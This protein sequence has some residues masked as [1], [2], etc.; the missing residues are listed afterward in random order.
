M[1][2]VICFNSAINFASSLVF[3]ISAYYAWVYKNSL[4]FTQGCILILLSSI[5]YHG[6]RTLK[7]DTDLIESLKIIDIINVHVCTL[8]FTYLSFGFNIWYGLWWIC[9]LYM[10]TSYYMLNASNHPEYG[11]YLHSS[12]HLIGNLG[13]LFMIESYFL[14]VTLT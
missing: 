5:L 9:I 7:L 10:V 8:Y 4:Q 13:I 1:N 11:Y 6:A 12:Y 3:G 2:L 14:M